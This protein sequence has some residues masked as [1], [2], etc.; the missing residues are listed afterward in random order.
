MR[1][2]LKEL[3]AL[4]DS[5]KEIRVGIIGTGKMGRNLFTQLYKLDG[6]KPMFL[7][8]R[9][10]SKAIDALN[11]LEINNYA[12]VD[13]LRDSEKILQE[14]KIAVSSDINLPI[15]S[16][17]IDVIVDATGNPK[18]GAEIAFNS[19]MN[20]KHIIMLNVECDATI[21]PI[22]SKLAK[23]NGVVYSG[24]K[25][26]EPGAIIELV[27]FAEMLGLEVLACGKGKNNELNR[28]VTNE[29]L[30]EKADNSLLNPRMLTSFVD[31]TN[32]MIEMT[33]LA[34]AIGF[35]VD[36]DGMHG[37]T[38]NPNDCASKYLLK[39]EGGI[40]DSY[41][42]VDFAFGMAP[43]VF[44]VVSTDDEE[45][46]GIFKYLGFGDGPNYTIYRPYHLISLE[47]P[48][49]IYEAVINH[50]SSI[51]GE[52]GRM[53]DTIAVSKRKLKKGDASGYIGSNNSYGIIVNRKDQELGNLVPIGLLD[54]NST[55]KVDVKEDTYLTY[56]MVNLDKNSLIYKLRMKQD[57]EG[58]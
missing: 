46:K 27:E 42:I 36:K 52:Y 41:K 49:S 37:V 55:M 32:T 8:N 33:S 48:I 31:G 10:I 26:D 2:E 22:L 9:T 20:H 19:I 34:N 14:G 11:R 53:V 29:E 23:E 35:K 54:N 47:T 25:G 44:V 40:L 58:L 45:I 50:D 39:N 30:K 13:N 57:Q 17:Y 38:T 15:E 16:N 7:V 5:N 18:A 43:G 21:G 3:K 6:F 28:H 1:R 51:N 56:D 24:T 4:K 12:E